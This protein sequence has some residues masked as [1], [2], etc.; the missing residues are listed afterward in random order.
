MTSKLAWKNIWRNKTRSFVFIAA[1]TIGFAMALFTLNSMKSIAEQRLSDAINIQTS[2]IQVHKKGFM[3]DKEITFTIPQ[4]EQ[5]I[6]KLKSIAGIHTIAKRISA[7]AVVASPENNIACEIKGIVPN[8]ENQISVL[9]DFLIEGEALNEEQT[10]P[11]LVSKRTAEKLKLKLESKVIVTLKSAGGEIV[12]GAFRVAGIFVTPSTPYDE[13][14]VIA[15]FN[16]LKELSGIVEP[17]ELAIKVEDPSIIADV[18]TAITSSL[19]SDYEVSDWKYLLPELFAFDG[20]INMVGVLFTIIIILGLGFSLMNTMNMIVQERTKEIGMLR[21]I[22]QG[23]WSVFNMLLKESGLMMM[24]GA[25]TGILL[26]L[27]FIS[28]ASESGIR[29]S[30]DLGFLGI[31][32]IIY[33]KINMSLVVMIVIMATMLTVVISALP[34]TKALRI[35]ANEALKD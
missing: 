28:L 13:G 24:V 2:F 19:S 33:P 8:E 31:R 4:S 11:I 9:K 1:A 25:S 16:D 30:D 22:G 32:P 20:F 18:M 26:G 3:D 27:V 23:K 29:I 5:V 21:A 15:R 14:T 34:A 10:L 12:G 6:S 17:H 7:N 35:K